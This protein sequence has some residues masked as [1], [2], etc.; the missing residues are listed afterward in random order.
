MSA[1]LLAQRLRYE[2]RILGIVTAG[3]PI[4][5]AV[6]YLGFSSLAGAAALR[7]GGTDAFM[8]FQAG[9]GLLGLLEN[10]LPLAGGLIAAISISQNP[11]LELH[12]SLPARYQRVGALR[13]TLITCWTVAFTGVVAALVAVTGFWLSFQQTLP[14][15]ESA[16]VWLAPLLWFVAAGA[17]LA[18]ALRSRAASGAVLGLI[19]IAM[20]VFKQQ[21]LADSTFQ[22]VYLFLTEEAGMPPYW[23]A[24]RLIVLAMALALF[25]LALWLLGRNESLLHDEA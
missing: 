19:W 22:Q 5:V 17:A 9:R 18:L 7:N 10:G 11:A 4:I 21:L 3:L 20:F 25:G 15:A 2:L 16:L 13:L 12:L 24:N 8:R 23:L 1:Q 6:I 14:P